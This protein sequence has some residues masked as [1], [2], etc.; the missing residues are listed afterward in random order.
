M[1]FAI[2]ALVSTKVF[3][4]FLCDQ[5]GDDPIYYLVA[6]Q[7]IDCASEEH[8]CVMWYARAMVLIYPLG[9]PLLYMTL[10]TKH[11]DALLANDRDEEKE[12]SDDIRKLAFLW[13]EYEP[14]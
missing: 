8:K 14:Q 5:Y 13:D 4:T 12:G 11:R 9:I 1:T 7:R 2:Y 10:L 6:N 3:N